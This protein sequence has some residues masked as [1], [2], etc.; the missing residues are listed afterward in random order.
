VAPMAR[1][2]REAGIAVAVC[3]PPDLGSVKALHAEGIGDVEFYTGAIVDL[4]A[5]ERA[6]EL[7][8]LGD[9]VR[10]A[11]KLHLGIGVAGGLGQ[12]NVRELL[13]AAP[14]VRTIVVGRAAVGRAL[15]VGLDR[16]LRDLRAAI[17]GPLTTG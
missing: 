1:T 2:L 17:G 6:L 12:R 10:L 13:E 4:P 11:S 3:V 7:E 5:R 8:R 16:A 15:L 9:A 14:A